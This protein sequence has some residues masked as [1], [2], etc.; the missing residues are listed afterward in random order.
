MS[1]FRPIITDPLVRDSWRRV[2][3]LWRPMAVWTLLVGLAMGL[4]LAP[5]ASMILGAGWF[6]IDDPVISNETLI[7]WF[8]S[9]VGLLYLLLAGALG[10]TSVVIRYAGLFEI[11][12]SDMSGRAHGIRGVVLQVLKSLP[13]LL[14][15]CLF[16]MAASLLLLL[17]VLA[18]GALLYLAL[19]GDHD[20]NFYISVQ[21]TEWYIA[22]VLFGV[23]VLAWLILTLY[24]AGRSLLALPAILTRDYALV[25]ALRTSWELAGSRTFR[26]LRLMGFAV[27]SWFL[28]RITLDLALIFIAGRAL[29]LMMATSI[30]LAVAGTGLFILLSVIQSVVVG[31]LGF[32]FGST[33]LTKYYYEGTDL[34]EKAVPPPRF[35]EVR[36]R[37][38]S[39]V[40]PWLAWRRMTPLILVLA[41][42]SL[43]ASGFWLDRL[44]EYQPVK[45][46][47]HRGGPPPLPENTVSAV[48]HS[49]E[50][51][52]DIVEI[53]VQITRDGVLVLAHDEDLMRIGRSALQIAT[54]DY[55]QLKDLVLR[56]A[57]I[58]GGG[59]TSPSSDSQYR[60]ATLPEILELV[61]GR[62]RLLIELKSYAGAGE[63]ERLVHEAVQQI[64]EHEMGDQVEIMTLDLEMLN[65]LRRVAPEIPSGFVSAFMIGDPRQIEADFLSVNQ[66][67][68]SPDLLQMGREQRL[69]IYVWTI[70]R[71]ERLVD[72]MLSGVDGIITD[73]PALARRIQEELV[74]MTTVER[75]LLRFRRLIIDEE[76]SGDGA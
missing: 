17:P 62:S 46:I 3:H 55:E 40:E 45:I 76:S 74:Q 22:L 51:G 27:S 23:W 56:P 61:R 11:V 10:L 14:R 29:N 13:V 25:D 12:T 63:S 72:M 43:F 75:L 36:A 67:G 48:E 28:V 9:P 59:S 1:S 57:R 50:I 19:L 37:L 47:A 66:Q 4:I 69:P 64:R 68:L 71:R 33:L 53:D 65:Q 16:T 2:I 34:H 18:G 35:R 15:V 49:M 32:S 58:E 70:N 38:G 5:V 42:G 31:F 8:A 52:V 6:R 21:P 7:R 20:I 44:P 73:E 30:R 39:H 54:S 24:L 60:I 41:G 26:L